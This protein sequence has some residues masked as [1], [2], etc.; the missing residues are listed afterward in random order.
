MTK[1]KSYLI[2]V[3]GGKEVIAK[4][5]ENEGKYYVLEFE[6]SKKPKKID[7][8]RFESGFACLEGTDHI[9]IKEI[10]Q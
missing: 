3:P 1:G 10:K 4:F 5:I 8:M 9:I 7:R 6:T 2:Q